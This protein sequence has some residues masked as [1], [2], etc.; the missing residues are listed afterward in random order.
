M[1][2]VYLILGSNIRPVEN[3]PAVLQRL[4]CLFRVL[5]VSSTWESR[6]VGSSGPNFLNTA[7]LIETELDP[8]RLKYEVLRPLEAEFGRVRTADK[9]APRTLDIDILIYDHTILDES[10]WSRAH[11]AVPLSELYPRLRHPDTYETLD[12][13]ADC[14]QENE[15]IVKRTD[16]ITRQARALGGQ[17]KNCD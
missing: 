9:N 15:H 10:I 8:L 14:I 7:V 6:A 4:R 1:H 12:A 11:L 2:H 16:V 5:A 3:L 13:L 17:N